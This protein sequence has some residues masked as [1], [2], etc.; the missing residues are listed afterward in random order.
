[1]TNTTTTQLHYTADQ[2]TTATI[3]RPKVALP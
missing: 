1:M 2:F 3:T